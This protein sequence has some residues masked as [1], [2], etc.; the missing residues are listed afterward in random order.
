MGTDLVTINSGGFF[1]SDE[2]AQGLGLDSAFGV[3]L[4]AKEARAFVLLHEFGHMK[5]FGSEIDGQQ[6]AQGRWSPSANDT[7]DK[8]IL[9]DCFGKTVQW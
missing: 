1:F 9:Q 8:L 4:S 2:V 6:D 3:T 5:G 7:F